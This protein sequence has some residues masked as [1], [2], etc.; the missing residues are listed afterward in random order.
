M[1]AI[2]ICALL[3][4]ILGATLLYWVGYRGGLIDGRAE[5]HRPSATDGPTG[6]RTSVESGMKSDQHTTEAS[7]ALLRNVG[8]V[9]AQETKILCCAA[10]GITKPVCATA[11]ALIPHEKLREAGHLD[12]TLIAQNRLPAQPAVGYT[13]PLS[14]R[15]VP[16]VSDGQRLRTVEAASHQ[17]CSKHHQIEG[18]EQRVREIN[19]GS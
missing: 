13:H 7:T 9:D 5:G 16:N 14:A 15:F 11:E 6:D 10:A 17:K 18:I 1:T 12:A 19:H 4:L 8:M 2:Q 3:S